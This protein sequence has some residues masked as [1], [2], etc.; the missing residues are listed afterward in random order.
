MTIFFTCGANLIIMI[1]LNWAFDTSKERHQQPAINALLNRNFV[2]IDNSEE[3]LSC[4]DKRP[5]KDALSICKALKTG[6]IT[7]YF[8]RLEKRPQK[9]IIRIFLGIIHSK[10]SG[11]PILCDEEM[12]IVKIDGISFDPIPNIQAR[13]MTKIT[14]LLLIERE[15]Q[16]SG[17]WNQLQQQW[18][19]Q[20]TMDTKMY[21]RILEAIAKQCENYGQKDKAAELFKS[22]KL[23]KEANIQYAI[24]W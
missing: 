12:P 17:I 14:M 23:I 21:V 8:E 1:K 22:I 15:S 18:T 20:Y 3:N 9:K 19:E 16:K 5:T 24:D 10:S 7:E 13:M 4:P 2:K 6:K 11:L